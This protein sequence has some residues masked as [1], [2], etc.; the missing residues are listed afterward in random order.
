VVAGQRNSPRGTADAVFLMIHDQPPSRALALSANN[1]IISRADHTAE[2]DTLRMVGRHL[3]QSGTS[4]DAAAWD[5]AVAEICALA[6]R[7]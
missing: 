7:C 6:S 2:G 3:L 1:L 4:G 5:A